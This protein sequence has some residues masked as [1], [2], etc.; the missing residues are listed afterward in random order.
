MPIV[1]TVGKKSRVNVSVQS[2]VV[3]IMVLSGELK[4]WCGNDVKEG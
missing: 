2:P 1:V 4:V 3:A